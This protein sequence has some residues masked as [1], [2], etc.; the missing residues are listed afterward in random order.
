[1]NLTQKLLGYLNRVFDKGP[2]RVLVLRFRY[3]GTAMS[4]R[5]DRKSV[6]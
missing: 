4:W 1:M 5:I 3:D 2:D 6:V